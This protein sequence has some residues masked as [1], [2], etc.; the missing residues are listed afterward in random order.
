MLGVLQSLPEELAGAEA[1]ARVQLQRLQG[2]LPPCVPQQIHIR[3]RQLP[4]PWFGAC[5]RTRTAACMRRIKVLAGANACLCCRYAVG[6]SR[7]ASQIQ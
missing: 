5:G 6:S 4:H 3:D 7:S 2:R 1:Q